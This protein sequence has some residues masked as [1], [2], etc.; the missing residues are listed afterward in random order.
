[1]R[2]CAARAG[3]LFPAG[4]IK[5]SMGSA[6]GSAI[7]RRLRRPLVGTNLLAAALG[8]FTLAQ[9]SA[10]LYASEATLAGM[11]HRGRDP[12]RYAAPHR[13]RGRG[14]WH[15]RGRAGAV[16]DSFRL[17]VSPLR[18][19]RLDVSGRLCPRRHPHAARDRTGWR[20]HRQAR[21]GRS[22]LLIPISLAARSGRYDGNFLHNR[23]NGGRRRNAVHRSSSPARANFR[24]RAPRVPGLSA[25][26]AGAARHN[27]P[28]SARSFEP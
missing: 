5:R 3:A 22:I 24:S 26:P 16:P 20:I 14:P 7:C 18:R 15:R 13:L 12:R 25:L 27:G 28:G 10:A 9:L 19:H 11:H 8:L 4:R 17:A 23:R 2:R 1:M 6:S 21:C